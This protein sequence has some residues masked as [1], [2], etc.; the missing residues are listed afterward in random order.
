[1]K[2]ITK[3]KKCLAILNISLASQLSLNENHALNVAK[4]NGTAFE[5]IIANKVFKQVN[6]IV[7][8]GKFDIKSLNGKNYE[9]KALSYN[10]HANFIKASE[11]KEYQKFNVE[12]NITYVFNLDNKVYTMNSITFNKLINTELLETKYRNQKLNDELQIIGK[13]ANAK[14]IVQFG[15]YQPLWSNYLPR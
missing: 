12:N 5:Y 3:E 13:Q 11:L 1:M 7:K 10:S 8:K 14:T 4:N 9:F 2:Y 15:K 6:H